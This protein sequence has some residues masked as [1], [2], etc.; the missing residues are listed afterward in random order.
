M[1]KEQSYELYIWRFFLE[2]G[3]SFANFTLLNGVFLI[4]F[5]LTLGASE[6]QIGILMSIPLLAN[7]LQI[8]SAFILERTGTR[9][10]TAVVSLL[11]SR[12]LWIFIVFAIFG[13][14]TFPHLLYL[15][16][17]VL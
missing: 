14:I 7:L 8:T 17:A 10:W 15:F 11:I 4:G 16:G 2:G 6:L 9:K 13:V 1:G 3:L 12:V 5:A